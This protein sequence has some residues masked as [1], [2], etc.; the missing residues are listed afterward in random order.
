MNPESVTINCWPA[1]MKESLAIRY[2]DGETFWNELR[3]TY[4]DELKPVGRTP[5]RG[6]LRFRKEAI[7]KA[8][9]LAEMEGA[10]VHEVAKKTKGK[11]AV[12]A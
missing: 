5:D 3:E 7:D 2:V 12:P 9:L 1:V 6:I 11:K 10:L 8:L 4:A